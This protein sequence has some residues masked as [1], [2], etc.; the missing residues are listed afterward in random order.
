M[1]TFGGNHSCNFH[2]FDYTYSHSQT[3]SENSSNSAQLWTPCELSYLGAISDI[4]EIDV[5][6]KESAPFMTSSENAEY[7]F[8]PENE[9]PEAYNLSPAVMESTGVDEEK[10]RMSCVYDLIY[11][12][13]S[14]KDE[15]SRHEN[16]WLS[17]NNDKINFTDSV[18]TG[19]SDDYNI[20]EPRKL[21]VNPDFLPGSNEPG[22]GKIHVSEY[23]TDEHT[24]LEMHSNVYN[25][26]EKITFN[27]KEHISSK[28]YNN[29]VAGPSGMYPRKKKFPCPL[30]PK[31]FN[32]KCNLDSH[33]R[34][35]TGNMVTF[36]ATCNNI[37]LATFI[38]ST[39]H[40]RE[41]DV[42]TKESAP[43]TGSSENAESCYIPENDFGEA[44]CILATAM[45]STAFD[46]EKQTESGISV[47]IHDPSREQDEISC[48]EN[49]WMSLNNDNKYIM[50][51]VECAIRTGHSDN[52]NISGLS[53]LVVK[54]DFISG[55]ND[56]LEYVTDEHTSL[57]IH[58]KV[59]SKGEKTATIV[60]EHISSKTDNNAVAGPSGMCPQRK[61]FH[62]KLY[63]KVF[64]QKYHLDNHYQTHTGEKPF[65]CELCGKEFS[66]KGS[67]DRHYRTHTGN[68]PFVCDFCNKGF[69]QNSDLKIHIRT[70]TG[71]RP[72]KCPTCGKTFTNRSVCKMH[73]KRKHE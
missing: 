35:H 20:S 72:Y 43:F 1:V 3:F 38:H 26:S 55:S 46:E 64:N 28:T 25:K 68:R 50:D 67:R 6:T 12:T 65:V 47:P 51:S 22:K 19:H 48:Q 61:T 39:I 15:M 37:T 11:A 44:Y 62:C 10:Q 31:E 40:I 33:Y 4:R 2:T 7:C 58:S 69:V 14:E 73:H 13:G 53:N 49:K 41:I 52:S 27:L 29:A 54:P 71:E 24:S 32:Q 18:W 56:V 42:Q 36:G 21:I 57:E 34:T 70:H 60:K 66:Q 5:Q 16:K 59:Y 63:P 30:C 8:R 45:E 23:I 9:F 17:L